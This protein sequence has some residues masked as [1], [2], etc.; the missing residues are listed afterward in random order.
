MILGDI[1]LAVFCV[2]FL[3]MAW[4]I[5]RATG[6][7]KAILDERRTALDEWSAALDRRGEALDRL[8]AVVN[9]RIAATDRYAAALKEAYSAVSAPKKEVMQ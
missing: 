8:T 2:S 9:S 7:L 1:L 3:V 4:S 6:K 5:S